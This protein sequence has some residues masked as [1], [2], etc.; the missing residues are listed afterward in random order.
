MTDLLSVLRSD[1]GFA[2][3]RGP[4]RNETKPKHTGEIKGGGWDTKTL[5]RGNE[6]GGRKQGRDLRDSGEAHICIEAQ[7]SMQVW[8]ISK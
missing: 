8:D 7:R 5:L 3:R 6:D 2:G 4:Q 1:L